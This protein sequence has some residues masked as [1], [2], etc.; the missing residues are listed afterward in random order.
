ML[1]AATVAPLGDD[2]RKT[3]CLLV[4]PIFQSLYADCATWVA[5]YS[6]IVYSHLVLTGFC[7]LTVPLVAPDAI[8]LKRVI[9]RNPAVPVRSIAHERLESEMLGAPESPCIV[10]TQRSAKWLAGMLA[11]GSIRDVV[12][13]L[14]APD[15]N[16]TPGWLDVYPVDITIASSNPITIESDCIIIF[17]N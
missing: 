13:L 7:S 11:V 3:S 9:R 6:T 17:S 16:P 14:G 4:P 15:S 1:K 12:L 2:A 5:W 8:L 10:V